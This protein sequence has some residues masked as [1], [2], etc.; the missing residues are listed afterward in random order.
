MVEDADKEFW[1]VD[2]CNNCKDLEIMDPNEVPCHHPFYC[3][4]DGG[5]VQRMEYALGLFKEKERL[6]GFLSRGEVEVVGFLRSQKREL[7]IRKLKEFRKHGGK[8]K[9]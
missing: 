9:F 4:K 1:Y 6:H 5:D 8:V 3:W 7:V 2:Y